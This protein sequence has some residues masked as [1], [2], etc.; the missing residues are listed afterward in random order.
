MLRFKT[1]LMKNMC[2]TV[3]AGALMC[4]LTVVFTARPAAAQTAWDHYQKALDYQSA[5]D[6][7][8]AVKELRKAVEADPESPYYHAALGLLYFNTSKCE[9]AIPE[10]NKALDMDDK[11]LD[12][13]IALGTCHIVQGEYDTAVE[14][15]NK[16][17]ALNPPEKSDVATLY[18]NLGQIYDI[19]G[20]KDKAEE[21]LLKAKTTD[22]DL[23]TTYINLGNL[24]TS[25]EQFEKAVAEYREAARR[26]PD[27][28]LVYNNLAFVLLSMEQYEEAI[29]V[30]NKAVELEPGN[31]YYQ[32]NLT[33]AQQMMD[34]KKN[35]I[36]EGTLAGLPEEIVLPPQG[37]S[38][39]RIEKPDTATPVNVA[40]ANTSDT[41]SEKPETDTVAT[42]QPN[43]TTPQTNP[44]TT[45]TQ[46]ETTTEK[47]E[48]QPVVV[49]KKPDTAE[50]A[51]VAV[52]VPVTM[53]YEAQPGA[54]TAAPVAFTQTVSDFYT[55]AL[56][57][58]DAGNM[59][60][61]SHD[62]GRAL[63]ED[64]TN[65]NYLFVQGM[66]LMEKGDEEAAA[67]RFNRALEIQPAHGPA[68]NALGYIYDSLGQE[69]SAQ[70][71][72]REALDADPDDG[73]A[74][75]SLAAARVRQGMCDQD[76]MD[77][78]AKAEENYCP[79][80]E[81]LNNRALCDFLGD[82]IG[83]AYALTFEALK[84]EPENPVIKDNFNF[85]VEKSGMPFDLVRD[86]KPQ[87]KEIFQRSEVMAADFPL[88]HMPPMHA[89]DFYEVFLDNWQ[90]RVVLII[91]YENP[92]GVRNYSPTPSEIY[93]DRLA[94]S[95]DR[96][97][98]FRT[99]VHHGG[100][101]YSYEELMSD[102]LLRRI[103][104][105]YPEAEV[106]Y[107]GRL[108]RARVQESDRR[109]S[110]GLKKKQVLEATSNMKT[111][112]LLTSTL[113][114]I[115]NGNLTGQVDVPDMLEGE[116]SYQD[117]ENIKE[118]VFDDYSGK[119]HEMLMDHYNLL[120]HPTEHKYVKSVP[121][122]EPHYTPYHQ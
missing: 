65:P 24:Y 100:T 107:V 55:A 103:V 35:V 60:E 61:A 64:P 74:A 5:G 83:N 32:E 4:L 119:I 14:R 77:L 109:V 67:A 84:K 3:F 2:K 59:D 50:E 39:S 86:F 97:G 101:L 43:E 70:L 102:G 105:D 73:C 117:M 42:S 108:D 98:Y 34:R 62:I 120:R 37:G 29:T 68:H 53:V 25:Q 79:H 56:Y 85:M 116:V 21:Y 89:L 58:F 95:I 49:Q 20:Q 113:D 94:T 80:G 48:T 30:M 13:H 93:T 28:S 45:V 81:L 44:E 36:K 76:T 87:P 52:V 88:N 18:N 78:F 46:P 111:A 1:S 41:S 31:S 57:N 118:M 26:A 121:Y 11:I 6:V 92:R 47:T 17:L 90:P 40:S 9:L 16:A 71:H 82:D 115:Y 106:V 66:I 72:Y 96:G 10:L 8:N 122:E 27:Y 33:Y 51:T 75:A 22:P 15:F 38:T 12:A 99:I 63:A 23:I 110:Y 69:H 54:V 114:P 104:N 7:D 19:Q 112:L 91:P